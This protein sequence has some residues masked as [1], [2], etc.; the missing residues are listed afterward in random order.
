MSCRVWE[1]SEEGEE[2]LHEKGTQRRQQF[3]K[4]SRL[5]RHKR[6]AKLHGALPAAKSGGLCPRGMRLAPLSPVH[7][8]VGCQLAAGISHHVPVEGVGSNDV[9]LQG[10][11]E[12]SRQAGRQAGEVRQVR[13]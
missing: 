12:E 5:M 13:S 1:G 7:R 3:G 6:L 10:W 4:S 11:R 8:V 9:E 2:A